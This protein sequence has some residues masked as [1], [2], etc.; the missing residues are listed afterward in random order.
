MDS[1]D[2]LTM[3]LGNT[4]K[5]FFSSWEQLRTIPAVISTQLVL[6]R[7]RVDAGAIFSQDNWLHSAG[8]ENFITT[9]IS[10]KEA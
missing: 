7:K 8:A 5:Q 4:G 2:S 10:D 1:V 9:D 3:L 6:I